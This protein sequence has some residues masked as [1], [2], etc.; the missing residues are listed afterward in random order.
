M[1]KTALPILA[2]LLALMALPTTAQQSGGAYDTDAISRMAETLSL[3]EVRI[4]PDDRGPDLTGRLPGGAMI[5]ID[6]H[7]DGSLD[8]I[9]AEGSELA[10][11]A[12]VVAILPQPLIGAEGFP[13]DGR[14]EEIDLDDGEFEIDGRDAEGRRFEAEYTASGQLKEFKRD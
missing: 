10:P 9:E 3:S 14:F 4:H 7:R 6:V 5:E 2:A 13:S 1:P 8:K 12:E 11:I